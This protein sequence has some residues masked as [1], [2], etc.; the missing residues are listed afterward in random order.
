MG[1]RKRNCLQKG[2]WQ[3]R[4]IP[5]K[6]LRNAQPSTSK[7][8]NPYDPEKIHSSSNP[9]TILSKLHLAKEQGMVGCKSRKIPTRLYTMQ[10]DRNTTHSTV[11]RINPT[12][13]YSNIL[14][15]RDQ[16]KD[17]HQQ[18]SNPYP[19]SLNFLTVQSVLLMK[20]PVT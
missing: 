16:T 10:Y 20:L 1:I 2:R 13:S 3:P 14:P 12:P 5:P 7:P 15:G 9:D 4:T 6:R 11:W 18:T 8:T 17:H 19:G